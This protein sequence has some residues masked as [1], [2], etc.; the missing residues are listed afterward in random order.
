MG[1]SE[2]GIVA[3]PTGE[4]M[5]MGERVAEAECEEMF[6]MPESGIVGFAIVFEAADAA[7]GRIG[8]PI[9]VS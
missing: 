5:E 2:S 4:E 6:T 8:W 1:R 9:G 7:V 3:P